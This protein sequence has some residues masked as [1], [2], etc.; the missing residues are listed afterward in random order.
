MID[1]DPNAVV[2][3]QVREA[4]GR[5]MSAFSSGSTDEYFECFHE[6]ASFIFPREALLEPRSAYHA[7]WSQW[8]RE[9]VRFTDVVADD[10]RV[11]VFGETAVVTH[12]LR[13]TVAVQEHETIDR[14]RESIVFTHVG[15]RW[16]AVHEHLSAEET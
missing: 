15:A 16:L 6:D 4:Y 2:V 8:Q 3:S 5:L 12:R 10:I 14:E 1:E 11:R 7:A 9:G 13:T